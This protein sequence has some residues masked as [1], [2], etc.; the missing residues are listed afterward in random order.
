MQTKDNQ[1]RIVNFENDVHCMPQD[2]IEE[3]LPDVNCWCN[4]KID[5]KNKQDIL[6]GLAH[7]HVWVHRQIK[8]NRE[9]LN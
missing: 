1:V 5:E 9:E 4:P 6:R 7:K 2:D 3:H 8:Y